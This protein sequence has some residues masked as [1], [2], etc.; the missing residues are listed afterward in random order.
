MRIL[1]T[2][3]GKSGSWA[4][5]G[6]QL[7]HAIGATVQPLATN[8]EGFD[9]VILVKRP[10]GVIPRRL[11]LVW[12]VVDAFPQPKANSWTRAEC[13]AWLADQ[14]SIIRPDGIVAATEVMAV[15]CE[16]FGLPVLWLPHHSRP[17]QS[18]N[19]IRP[20]S[21]IGYEG[22]EAHLGRWRVVAEAECAR[23]GWQFL[24]NPPQLADV[25]VVL[26]LRDAYGYAPRNYK[27]N[28]KLANAQGSGTPIV[29]GREA[30]YLE[31][32]CGSERWADTPSELQ[33][34]FDE[35]EPVAVR[36]AASKRLLAAVPTLDQMANRY[37]TW[38][39]ANF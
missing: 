35:L 39:E 2:G 6:Q 9:L 14:V 18:I 32:Q 36:S 20:L 24:L 30:G 5:R 16:M 34:A 10:R 8:F 26:A 12:D 13:L 25:D 23:R 33:I 19:P 21:V 27:S 38:L 4:I 3:S 11:P 29:C 15:D 28:V 1:I 31:T 22:S 7:G 17:G 37:S